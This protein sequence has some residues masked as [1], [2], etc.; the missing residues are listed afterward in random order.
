[1]ENVM[2]NKKQGIAGIVKGVL[3]A[4]A[5]TVVAVL[6]LAILYKFINMSDTVIKVANQIIKIA[7]IALGVKIATKKDKSKGLLK[8]AIIGALYTVLSFFLFSILASSFSFTL[9]LLFDI[10]FASVIG[11]IFG[12]IF[13]NA[14]K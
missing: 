1:M 2:S 10:L 13:V 9:G 3:F 4:L 11:L 6:V 14:K 7:S 8:G 5:L 12:V